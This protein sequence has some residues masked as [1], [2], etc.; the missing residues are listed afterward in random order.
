MSDRSPWGAAIIGGTQIQE[1][2]QEP[3]EAGDLK[4]EEEG[5][6]D[7]VPSGPA[8]AAEAPT[9]AAYTRSAQHGRLRTGWP[10]A[11]ARWVHLFGVAW[12][13]CRA[14]GGMS[15]VCTY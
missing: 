13:L 14:Y 8:A 7:A 5:T 12:D 1:Q 15:V 6:G 2:E 9:F 4:Q 3:S 10:A 11:S